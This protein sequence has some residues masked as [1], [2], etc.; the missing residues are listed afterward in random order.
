MRSLSVEVDGA[1]DLTF[2]TSRWTAPADPVDQ[3]VLD[4]VIPPVI[5]VGCGPGRHVDALSRRGVPAM[6]VDITPA[7]VDDARS[8]GL[9]VLERSVHDHLPGLGRWGSALL[10]DG[11]LGIGGDPAGLLLRVAALVRSGG[12]VL[13]EVECPGGRDEVAA[14]RLACGAT[15]GPWFGWSRVSA[16]DVMGSCPRGLEL[17]RTWQ[18][19]GRWF[20]HLDRV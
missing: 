1:S 14:I 16:E 11:N 17:R 6:G 19:G 20:M 8:R 7:L 4:L 12:R 10:L 5:D 2:P 3:G 15:A 9:A 18:T 13:A